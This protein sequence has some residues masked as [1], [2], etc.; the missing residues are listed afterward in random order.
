MSDPVSNADIEDVLSSIRRLVS[1][2]P[3][4]GHGGRKPV[5][6][7]QAERFVLT[8]AFRVASHPDAEV[9]AEAEAET[10]PEAG[11]TPAQA[12]ADESDHVAADETD[13]RPD[14]S[15]ADIGIAE[16]RAPEPQISQDY[17]GDTEWSDDGGDEMTRAADPEDYALSEP[18]PHKPMADLSLEERIAELEA[19]IE[20]APQEWEPDGSEDG[21][22]DLTRP[23]SY[24]AGVG[25]GDL[26]E[27]VATGPEEAEQ[28]AGAAGADTDAVESGAV[29]TEPVVSAPEAE[30]TTA[31]DSGAVDEPAAWQV[32]KS[33]EPAESHESF[34]DAEFESVRAGKTP[35][36]SAPAEA[37]VEAPAP[38]DQPSDWRDAGTEAAAD[39]RDN[40]SSELAP[41]TAQAWEDAAPE[42][43]GNPI[44]VQPDEAAEIPALDQSEDSAADQVDEGGNLLADDEATL[45]EESLREMVGDLVRQELQGVLGERITRN[46]RR[47]V[48]REIQRAMAMRD[49]E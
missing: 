24:D 42:S 37:S 41:E 18:E 9:E 45:D 34:A 32:D 3:A 22:S 7:G 11:D 27:V 47:L 48:R 49:L 36:V 14:G 33:E 15:E 2:E 4:G 8:P 29:W 30:E 46:V 40:E 1:E 19:A 5:A 38:D 16:Y 25:S 20:Q 17:Q 44:E 26:D 21:S 23:I 31:P 35:P 13:T 28:T 43:A 6:D 10:L 39:Q 12:N